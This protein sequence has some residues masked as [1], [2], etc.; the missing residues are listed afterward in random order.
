MTTKR[1]SKTKLGKYERLL[2]KFDGTLES[3]PAEVEEEVLDLYAETGSIQALEAKYDIPVEIIRVVLDQPGLFQKALD[4]KRGVLSLD[5]V[6]KVLPAAMDRAASGESGSIMAAK[7]VAQVIGAVEGRSPGR[8]KAKGDE[9]GGLSV[10]ER[11]QRAHDKS[12]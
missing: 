9:D 3:V 12:R 1:G 7:L 10:E 4:R 5:F 6:S 2:Q 8:P 11:L